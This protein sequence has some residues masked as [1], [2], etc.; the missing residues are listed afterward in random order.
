MMKIGAQMYTV[1]EF[2]KDLDSFS[3]TLGK[4]ADI[5]FKSVQ[6]SGTCQ[7]EGE[8]LNEQLKKYGLECAIT[9]SPV[10]DADTDMLIEKHNKFNCDYIGLGFY[11][12]RDNSLEEFENKVRPII[13]KFKAAGKTFS[14]H[15]HSE[16]F[17]KENGENVMEKL[18]K[19]FTKDEMCFTLDTHWVQ[20]SGADPVQWLE[21]LAGR[22]PCI[23]LK[24]TEL[25]MEEKNRELRY[26]PVGSGNMNFEAILAACDKAEVKYGLIEQDNCYGRD[27]FECLAESLAYLR[28][29]GYKD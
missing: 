13:A 10:M 6:V 24:D 11:S 5:G 25:Y 17:L 26:A 28:S 9:H 27:P 1:R 4:L 23:H 15:N 2:C 8:W 14:Y 22:V 7:Y 29:M 16:E 20:V 3:N 12:F 19:T 21:K 18:M